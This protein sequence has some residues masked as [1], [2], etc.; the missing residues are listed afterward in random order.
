MNRLSIALLALVV[1]V[2]PSLAAK[3]YIDYDKDADQ[4]AYKTW[5]YH[6]NKEGRVDDPLMDE[7]LVNGLKEMMKK[8][9]LE[10]TDEAADLYVTYTVTTEDRTQYS[11]VSTGFG[12][13][14]PGGWG[15]YGRWGYSGYG[16]GY[17][18]VGTA[19]TTATTYTDGTIVIDAWDPKTEKLV[20]RGSATETLKVKPEKI[21]KQID[22]MYTQ[23]W[24]RWE[25]MKAKAKK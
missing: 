7:R 17:G 21:A 1:T 14:Y 3:V 11:T 20:W 9:S 5:S 23:L 25:K 22:K 18:G 13:G 4:N 6:E 10:E 19:T 8:S 2:T 16:Y 15:G 12:Y 24:S